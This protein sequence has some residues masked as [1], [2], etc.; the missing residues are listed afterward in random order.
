MV[1]AASTWLGSSAIAQP[2][3]GNLVL[4]PSKGA[5]G[6]HVTFEGDVDPSLI[7]QMRQPA[8]FN[9]IRTF[10]EGGCELILDLVG[11]TIDVDDAG[12]VSG[13]FTV[14]REGVCFQ[15]DGSVV[16]AVPGVYYLAIGCHA[17]F[18]GQFEISGRGLARTGGSSLALAAAGAG[19]IGVGV[20]LRRWSRRLRTG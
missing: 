8:Y 15:Q 17:C 9:L 19:L 20:L 5:V 2:D 13:S 4:N 11:A 1:L 3:P 7:G 14:G 6:T 16:T 12:H 18:V 10:P